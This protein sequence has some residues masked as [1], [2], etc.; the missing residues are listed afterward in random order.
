[1]AQQNDQSSNCEIVPKIVVTS[2]VEGYMSCILSNITLIRSEN[3]IVMVMWK[4]GI[5]IQFQQF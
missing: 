4:L 1:M 5:S 3:H 2:F